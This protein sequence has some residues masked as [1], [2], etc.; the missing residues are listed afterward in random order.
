MPNF[1]EIT[2][3]LRELAGVLR[4][5]VWF[6]DGD[7]KLTGEPVRLLFAGSEKQKAYISGMTFGQEYTEHYCGKLYAWQIFYLLR[8]KRSPCDIA[9][10]EGA[11]L[12]RALYQREK[13]TF[14]P[15]WLKTSSTAP[16]P[17]TR[18][19]YKD[20]L[21]IIRNSKLSYNVTVESDQVEDFYHNMYRPTVNASHGNSTIELDYDHMKSLFAKDKCILLQVIKDAAPIAGALVTLEEIPRLWAVGVRDNN[22]AYRKCC[23]NTA[24]YCFGAQYLAAQ[25]H[26]EM[27]L[28]MSRSFLNDG[29]L[30]YKN[31]FDQDIMG[32]DTTGFILKMLVH[33]AGTDGFLKGNPFVYLSG[34]QL[35]GAVF[36][37]DNQPPS[38]KE[39]QRLRK[40]YHLKGLAGL[41]IYLPG[42]SFGAFH[43]CVEY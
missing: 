13:D 40:K 8:N 29:I 14:L 12:H 39:L 32:I 1:A 22:P 28:G 24:A 27:H 30:Q 21:R 11:R 38:E 31:K 41:K 17:V 43:E 20:D 5:G 25:G 19:S 16:L 34:K 9:I 36:L 23:A 18:R 10:I 2:R 7:E 15:L 37:A 33:N 26:E 35:Y 42:Q 4:S 6:I 3:F